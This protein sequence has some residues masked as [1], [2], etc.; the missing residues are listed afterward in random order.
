MFPCIR[1]LCLS[2]INHA[3]MV[4]V[5]YYS[6]M[7]KQCIEKTI[8]YIDYQKLFPG[9]LSPANIWNESD[10]KSDEEDSLSNDYF[11][12]SENICFFVS[13]LWNER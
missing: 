4:K 13:N 11:E 7:T 8:S 6:R 12:Y 9:I 10:E 5:Y 3:G 1:V 2:D